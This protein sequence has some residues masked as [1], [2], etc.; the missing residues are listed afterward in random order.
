MKAAFFT[1]GRT[2]THSA[3]FHKFSGMSLS[4]ALRNSLNTAADSFNRFT[5]SFFNSANAELAT[6]HRATHRTAFFIM[7]DL[8]VL[9]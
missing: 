2:N 1:E 7:I 5:S 3:L 9:T 8:R 4:G 6:R